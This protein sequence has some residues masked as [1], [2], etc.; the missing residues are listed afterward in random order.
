MFITKSNPKKEETMPHLNKKTIL[1]LFIGLGLVWVS[2]RFLL[3]LVLPFL[4]GSALAL[5]AEPMVRR[6]SRK[7]PRAAATAIGVA[8]TLL[9]LSSI[10][11]LITAVTVRELG[12]LAAAVPDL[13][14]AA[15]GGLDALEGF[16]LSWAEKTPESVR[17]LMSR[18]VTGLFS[19][20]NAIVEQLLQRLPSLASTF[21]GWI[22]GS[23]VAL[24]T[25]ILSGFMVS[26]R[27]PKIR[28]W[29]LRLRS[30]EKLQ[31]YLPLLKQIRTALTGWLKAQLTLM[32]LCFA[33][34]CVG[35]F[36]LRVSYGPLWA[37]L[38]ALVDAIPILGTGTVLL[39]WGLVCL[40]QGQRIKA[41]GLLG[42]YVVALLSRSILEPRLVGKQLGLDP[43][44][45][46]VALYMG[47]HLW[48]I[49]GMLLSPMICVVFT[50]L[51]RGQS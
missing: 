18:S 4:L 17:P 21:L 36:L 20:G 28:A 49:P 45:T 46:L 5:A 35:F 26:A 13:G 50:Q 47:F 42:I 7:I 43:L 24:G 9:L 38:I 29:F 30:S 40:L 12:I 39:P 16:L 10:L 33:I 41:I 34:L 1:L 44:V 15:Q 48:G 19:S 31:K 6:L 3:P 23:A 25:G 27:F 51:A 14:R 37:F 11:V 2:I 32:C 8:A 22:P